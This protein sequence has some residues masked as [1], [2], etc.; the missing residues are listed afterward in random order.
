[1]LGAREDLGDLFIGEGGGGGDNTALDKVIC[2]CAT[3][4]SLR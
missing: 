1:M 3:K 2:H 4:N